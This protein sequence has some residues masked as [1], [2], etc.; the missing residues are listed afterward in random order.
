MCCKDR[1]IQ[2]LGDEGIGLPQKQSTDLR[3]ITVRSCVSLLV[4]A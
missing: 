4:T 3:S 1:L 2:G